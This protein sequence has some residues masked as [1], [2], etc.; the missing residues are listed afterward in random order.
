MLENFSLDISGGKKLAL[1]GA[2]GSG[3][4]TLIKLIAGYIYPQQGSIR[5]D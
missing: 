2:S 3:K 5:I 4:S 1:V